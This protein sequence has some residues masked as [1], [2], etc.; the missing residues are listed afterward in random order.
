MIIKYKH[1]KLVLSKL[2]TY[3]YKWSKNIHG[4]LKEL[5]YMYVDKHKQSFFTGLG[6]KK[7]ENRKLNLVHDK[8]E[9]VQYGVC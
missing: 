7:Y 9:G 1:G 3:N 6:N 2:L 5:W 4:A 8:G